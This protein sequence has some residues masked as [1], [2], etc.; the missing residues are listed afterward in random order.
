MGVFRE[1]EIDRIVVYGVL[2][3]GDTRYFLEYLFFGFVPYDEG[4][5]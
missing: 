1:I 4:Q 3:M 2:Q 5:V